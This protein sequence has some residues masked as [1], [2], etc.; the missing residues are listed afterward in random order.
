MIT[1]YILINTN[2][3]AV[4]EVIAV[5]KQRTFQI[6]RL[7]SDGF[8]FIFLLEA[9]TIC[10]CLLTRFYRG[11]SCSFLFLVLFDKKIWSKN[12]AGR[13]QSGN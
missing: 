10:S 5:K 2:D 3:L 8:F 11:V 12:I 9:S 13:L 4:T 6:I 7:R 1:I